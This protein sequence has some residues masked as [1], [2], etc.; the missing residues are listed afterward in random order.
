MPPKS[1]FRRLIAA[2]RA[3]S[4]DAVVDLL[5]RFRP[6]LTR[7]AKTRFD[8]KLKPKAGPSDVVQETILRAHQGLGSFRGDSEREAV[9]WLRRLLFNVLADMRRAYH[10]TTK[11]RL[12][13]ERRL[14]SGSRVLAARLR[15][16]GPTP[17][18]EL[19]AREDAL[20]V[21]RGMSRLA[22]EHRHIILLRC[23]EK[24]AFG[25][26][27]QRIGKSE[28]AARMAFHRAIG[29]LKAEVERGE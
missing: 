3:G 18:D 9:A 14:N 26:I 13:L 19:I 27:G 20:R 2:A 6:Y 4:P 1:E 8:G 16:D 22:D 11:R 24:L 5:E 7:V 10:V 29:M 12:N 17:P 28:D 23:H 15:H 21:E 25:E